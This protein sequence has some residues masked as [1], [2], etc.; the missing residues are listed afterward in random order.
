[1]VEV[2]VGAGRLPFNES[3]ILLQSTVGTGLRGGAA[4][5]VSSM[6]FAVLVLPSARSLTAMLAMNVRPTV[7]DVACAFNC[8]LRV[9]QVS[10]LCVTKAVMIFWLDSARACTC[11]LYIWFCRRPQPARP[12]KNRKPINGSHRRGRALPGGPGGPWSP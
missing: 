8:A 3:V 12:S 7:L 10:A 6:N 1:V 2:V 5:S 11:S 4:L 9:L